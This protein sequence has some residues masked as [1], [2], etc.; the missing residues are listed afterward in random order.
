MN[1]QQKKKKNSGAS[2]AVLVILIPL[3]MRALDGD[4]PPVVFGVIVI[5]VIAAIAFGKMAKTGK[6][7]RKTPWSRAETGR[8]PR[9]GENRRRWSSTARCPPCSA[10]NRRRSAA[11][12]SRMLTACPVS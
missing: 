12:R 6:K 3:L 8:R 10:A 2:W 1:N 7:R 11:F 5:A 4:L 9:R